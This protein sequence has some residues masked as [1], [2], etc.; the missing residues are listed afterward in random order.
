[1]PLAVEVLE[2]TAPARLRARAQGRDAAVQSLVKVELTLVLVETSTQ[3]TTLQVDADVTVLGKL[4]TLGHSVIVRRG[5]AI[6]EQFASAIQ[7]ALGQEV[8]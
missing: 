5:E 6:V 1:V 7:T 3:T 8:T 4:G 2:A